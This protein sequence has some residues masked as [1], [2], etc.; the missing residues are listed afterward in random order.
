MHVYGLCSVF[1][2]NYIYD[3]SCNLHTRCIHEEQCSN[4]VLKTDVCF[5]PY[6]Y[7]AKHTTDFDQVHLIYMS[8]YTCVQFVVAAE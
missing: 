4:Y 8:E 2:L 5:Q 3:D 6:Y 1:Q 7:Y